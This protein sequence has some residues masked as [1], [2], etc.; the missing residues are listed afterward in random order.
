MIAKPGSGHAT[1]DLERALMW[2]KVFRVTKSRTGIVGIVTVGITEFAVFSYNPLFFFF[3]HVSLRF[4][5]A[6]YT[7]AV[8]GDKTI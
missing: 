3:Y 6:F 4:T 2:R 1:R 8:C 5:S 7:G